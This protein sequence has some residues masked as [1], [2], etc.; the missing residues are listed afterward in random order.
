MAPKE[1]NI[2]FQKI[3]H[4]L[5]RRERERERKIYGQSTDQAAGFHCTSRLV[6]RRLKPSVDWTLY[7]FANPLLG[8]GLGPGFPCFLGY[9][10]YP[11]YQGYPTHS[12]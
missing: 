1:Y 5:P 8:G 12:Y 10:G 9:S 4:W 7:R 6:K 2:G 11:G 3:Q